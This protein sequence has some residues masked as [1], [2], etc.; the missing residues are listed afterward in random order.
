MREGRQVVGHIE[1]ARALESTAGCQW[2]PV[3]QS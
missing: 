1:V 2:L 3:I